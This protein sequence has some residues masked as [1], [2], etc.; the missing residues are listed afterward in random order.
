[1]QAFKLMDKTNDGFIT[2]EDLKGVYNVKKHPK[3]INGDWT[4]EQCLNEYLKT[5]E[6]TGNVDGKVRLKSL[7]T[8]PY[9][10]CIPGIATFVTWDGGGGAAM[11]P[12][13]HGQTCSH[14]DFGI[15][16]LRARA[17]WPPDQ[18]IIYGPAPLVQNEMVPLLHFMSQL[19]L[20]GCFRQTETSLF[21][22][23]IRLAENV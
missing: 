19:Q 21:L 13:C 15:K 7:F 12:G 11:F 4:E 18:N 22:F 6:A 16:I 10:H 14:A 5:F 9:V 3:Y 20:I 17:P 23:Q 1:M 2:K 8:K